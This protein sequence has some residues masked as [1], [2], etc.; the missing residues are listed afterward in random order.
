L[1]RRRVVLGW[2]SVIGLGLLTLKTWT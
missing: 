2:V 1:D